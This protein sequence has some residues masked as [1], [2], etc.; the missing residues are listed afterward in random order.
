MQIPPINP[1]DKQSGK[2]Q[3]AV[4]N[5]EDIEQVFAEEKKVEKIS[6]EENND[7][8]QSN[9]KDCG[10]WASIMEDLKGFFDKTKTETEIETEK[11]LEERGIINAHNINDVKNLNTYLEAK[12]QEYLVSHP[13]PVFNTEDN[14]GISILNQEEIKAQWLNELNMFLAQEGNKYRADNKISD[15]DNDSKIE[16]KD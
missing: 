5:E 2:M 13:E 3:N 7:I 4:N 15:S 16:K 10:I 9:K 14:P 6:V 1:N 11:I 12:R 8:P